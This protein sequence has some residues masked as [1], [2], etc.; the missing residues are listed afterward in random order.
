MVDKEMAS[1]E[2]Q[3]TRPLPRS[4]KVFAAIVIAFVAT[5]SAI[6]LIVHFAR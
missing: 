6:P 5:C 1:E 3:P 2:E 4:S